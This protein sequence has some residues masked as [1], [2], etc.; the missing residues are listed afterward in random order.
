M[1]PRR[2]RCLTGRAVVVVLSAAITS[3]DCVAEGTTSGEVAEGGVAVAHCRLCS[4]G[5][6]RTQTRR[7]CAPARAA[8]TRRLITKSS[9]HRPAPRGGGGA[10]GPRCPGTSLRQGGRARAR[11]G[12]V[13]AHCEQQALVRRARGDVPARFMAGFRPLGLEFAAFH[14]P[15]PC[16]SCRSAQAGAARGWV[17]GAAGAAEKIPRDAPDLAG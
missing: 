7:C 1:F 8:P 9:P 16:T 17:G 3:E 13:R 10:P 14:T 2:R 4:R 15:P 6:H 11:R 12:R 5:R